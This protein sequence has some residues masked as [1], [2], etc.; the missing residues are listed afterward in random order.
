MKYRE[1]ESLEHLEETLA[2]SQDKPVIV[3]KHSTRCPISSE[4]LKQ[5]EAY[6]DDAPNENAEYALVK[7]IEARPVS[8]AIAEE[9]NVEH[10]SPQAILIKGRESRWTASHWS[11]TKAKL[12]EALS[13]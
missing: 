13:Q 11:I 1:L 12:Q 7:V 3:L 6:L 5:F 8:N 10:Q 2:L 9:L 4:A